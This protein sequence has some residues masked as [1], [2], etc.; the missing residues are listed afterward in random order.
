MTPDQIRSALENADDLP[1]EALR[2]GMAV[3]P[4]LAPAVITVIEKAASG[5]ALSHGEWQLLFCGLHILAA[6]RDQSAYPAV[7]GLLGRSE[8]DMVELFTDE[9]IHTLARLLLGLFDGDAA[10][11]VAALEDQALDG[12]ARWAVFSA[13]ARLTWEGRVPQA[14]TL[15]VID[16]FEREGLAQD[17]DLAWEGWQNAI[18]YLGLEDRAD[19][20][21]AAWAAGRFP[22]QREADRR[23]WNALLAAAVADPRNEDRFIAD[24]IVP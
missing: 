15:E 9:S 14:V 18:M 13:L 10:P 11:L 3:A 19:R 7:M 2:A 12:G 4:E 23:E 24:H 8:E 17:G 22:L 1:I 16:R 5:A 20:V 21:R 6:A